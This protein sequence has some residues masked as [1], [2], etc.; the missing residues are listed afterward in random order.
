MK[1]RSSITK[2][3]C[4]KTNK[5]EATFIIWKNNMA[6]E[7]N[8]IGK[9]NYFLTNSNIFT[10][11]CVSLFIF[12]LQLQGF[13]RSLLRNVQNW[14]C[15]K[16]K[17]GKAKTL[18]HESYELVKRKLEIFFETWFI[19]PMENTESVS[20][21][22]LAPKKMKIEGLRELLET[23]WRYEARSISYSI[24]RWNSE[25]YSFADGYNEYHQVMIAHEDQLN[26][27]FIS[28]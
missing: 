12:W 2:T 16:R 9:K 28:P 3:T 13:A 1:K 15:A 27:T 20:L 5:I 22:T 7:S 26:T 11:F 18:P 14:V 6:V 23:E 10:I 17:G 19:Q 25:L 4:Y 21:I 8:T 24:L